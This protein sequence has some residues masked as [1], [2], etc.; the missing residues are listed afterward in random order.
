MGSWYKKLREAVLDKFD[1][2]CGACGYDA[3][4]RPL[5]VDHVEGGGSAERRA[6]VAVYQ[7]YQR[8]LADTK[9]EFRLLCANCNI[10]HKPIGRGGRPHGKPRWRFSPALG[11]IPPVGGGF[12]AQG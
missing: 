11:D 1:R 8:A 2:K 3:D 10:I 4:P 9:G 5:Q 6:K 12:Q 7:I